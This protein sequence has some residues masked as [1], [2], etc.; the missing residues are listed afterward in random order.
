M[1]ELYG[2]R[3][4]K[5]HLCRCVGQTHTTWKTFLDPAQTA[6]RIPGRSGRDHLIPLA[7]CPWYFGPARSNI[8]RR[9]VWSSIWGIHGWVVKVAPYGINDK[10]W[11]VL[12]LTVRMTCTPACSQMTTFGFLSPESG[13]LFAKC[14][15]SSEQIPKPKHWLQTPT[16]TAKYWTQTQSFDKNLKCL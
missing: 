13:C 7:T 15:K 1:L 9:K 10:I 6:P 11:T 4:C 5:Q 16:L 8:G 14:I 12:P 3:H 2:T